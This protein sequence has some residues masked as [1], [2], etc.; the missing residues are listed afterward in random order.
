MGEALGVFGTANN[1]SLGV[2]GVRILPG[3]SILFVKKNNTFTVRYKFLKNH[4]L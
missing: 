2:K 3:F 1:L 4:L